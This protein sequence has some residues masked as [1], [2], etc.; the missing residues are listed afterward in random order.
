MMPIPDRSD[1][2]H[3]QFAEA[4][5]TDLHRLA[6]LDRTHALRRTREDHVAR[7]ETEEP[8]EIGDRLSH[9]PDQVRDVALLLRFAVDGEPQAGLLEV[10]HARG[11][12]NRAER[13]GTIE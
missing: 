8:G 3:G 7:F 1:H 12:M 11:R 4:L 9:R 13:R 10:A 5:D 6:L 2:T